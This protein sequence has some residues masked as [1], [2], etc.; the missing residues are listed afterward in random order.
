MLAQPIAGGGLGSLAAQLGVYG[1]SAAV[2][3]G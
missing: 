3:R 2:N 1:G